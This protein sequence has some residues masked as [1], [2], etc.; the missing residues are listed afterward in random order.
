[1][2]HTNKPCKQ[3]QARTFEQAKAFYYQSL[4]IK[5]DLNDRYSQARTYHNLGIVAQEL[6]RV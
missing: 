4:A 2:W 6:R 1:M 5:E 3:R